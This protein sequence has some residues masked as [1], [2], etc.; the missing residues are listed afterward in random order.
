MKTNIRTTSME[1]QMLTAKEK[2]LSTVKDIG[3]RCSESVF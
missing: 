1:V 2:M 3:V